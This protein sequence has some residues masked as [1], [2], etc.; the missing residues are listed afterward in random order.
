MMRVRALV[1]LLMVIVGAAACGVPTAEKAAHRAPDGGA[2]EYFARPATEVYAAAQGV[3]AS[4]KRTPEWKELQVVHDDPS[5][6]VLIAE[7]RLEG[8]VPGLRV[9]DLWS[10]YVRPSD[11][12][13]AVTFV[14]ESSDAPTATVGARSW[15]KARSDIFPAMRETLGTSS[16][17]TPRQRPT[18][19]AAGV[20][21]SEEHA[22][23]AAASAR[24]SA[25]R[26]RPQSATS[27]DRIYAALSSSDEWRRAT[28]KRRIDGQEI[29]T[30]GS[31]AQLETRNGRVAIAFPSYPP[32]PAYDVARLMRFLADA[33]VEVDVLPGTAFRVE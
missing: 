18:T 10:F 23:G 1:G 9:R 7:R 29:V 27:T 4:A 8:I 19:P 15:A 32:P 33:G 22:H 14:L 13:T 30:V 20:A 17:A 5:A 12:L 25:D 16:T 3:V 31:W 21:P 11:D 6:G 24:A 26:D 2:T 28:H